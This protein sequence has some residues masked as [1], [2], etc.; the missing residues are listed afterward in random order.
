[1]AASLRHGLWND[2]D[3]HV[4]RLSL[5]DLDQT[6]RG[7]GGCPV[8]GWQ[9]VDPTS[10]SWRDRLSLDAQLPT[11]HASH[12][13]ELFQ[14][15][16]GDT[17][18]RH[19]DLRL[20]FTTLRVTDRAGEE[21]PL[22]EFIDGGIRWWDG[23]HAGDPRTGGNGIIS[24]SA[25]VGGSAAASAPTPSP[26]S[27]P[28]GDGAARDDGAVGGYVTIPNNGQSLEDFIAE[29]SRP[30]SREEMD[31]ARE[32]TRRN[33]SVVHYFPEAPDDP[34]TDP[35]ALDDDGEEEPL[36]TLR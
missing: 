29:Q 22:R 15:G 25:M 7:F 1:M 18:P 5:D 6:V 28:A 23:L 31:R 10:E 26:G 36:A 30:L 2:A 11:G 34:R 27:E 16:G 14:E 19:L 21:V 35:P 3:A 20:W 33:S 9:F 8:Y 12:V 4:E 17:G 13:L 24:G 32:R